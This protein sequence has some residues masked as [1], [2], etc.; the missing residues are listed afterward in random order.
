MHHIWQIP[1][2]DGGLRAV[3]W[4]S[5]SFSALTCNYQ[6]LFSKHSL[7]HCKVRGMVRTS[8]IFLIV[9]MS[10]LGRFPFISCLGPH[11][12]LSLPPLGIV[13]VCWSSCCTWKAIHSR[14]L[15]GG[16]LTDGEEEICH[17]LTDCFN[18]KKKP[19]PPC[20]NSSMLGPIRMQHQM[21]HVV[22]VLP[23]PW[24]KASRL[25]LLYSSEWLHGQ[26]GG[27]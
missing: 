4:G 14:S 20:F 27:R 8:D 21:W 3:V 16:H 25:R 6:L 9:S 12:F 23:W 18:S 10:L 7:S 22:Y 19:E 15:L 13:L 1:C 2:M 17:L 26:L 11:H 5:L 24:S